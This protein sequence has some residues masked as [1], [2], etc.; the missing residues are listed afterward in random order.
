MRNERFHQCFATYFFSIT[1][2]DQSINQ[3]SYRYLSTYKYMNIKKTQDTTKG[4]IKVFESCS[5][6]DERRRCVLGS[7]S[8][9]MNKKQ[10]EKI[11]KKKEK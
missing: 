10:K 1:N 7:S 6:L 11:Q 9:E 3:F 4:P 8:Y 2:G 5:H